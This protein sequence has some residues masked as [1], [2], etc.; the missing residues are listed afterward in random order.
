MISKLI[1]PEVQEFIQQ[2]V[3]EKP[4]DIA[5]KVQKYPHL[6][7]REIAGQ[8]A[9]R[10]KLKKKIP[11]WYTNFK[12]V[13]PPKENLEQASSQQTAEFKST[14][15]TGDTLLDLTG[16]TGVDSCFLSKKFKKGIYVEP[17]AMLCEL[18]RH[19]FDK[20]GASIDVV[21]AKAEEFL[22]TTTQH[23]DVIY[24]DPSRRTDTKERVF[25]LEQYSPNVLSFIGELRERGGRVIIKTSPMIDIKLAIDQLGGCQNVN[26]LA[27]ENEVKEVLF[28]LGENRNPAIEAINLLPNGAETRFRFTH[29]EERDAEV[30]FSGIENYI[31]D[32]NAAIRKAGGFKLS[33]F[34]FN[35]SKLGQHTHL[36]TSKE[37]VSNFPGRTFEVLEVLQP[38][39]KN[40]VKHV[41]S[42]KVNVMVRNYPET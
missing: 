5:L 40:V 4:T 7:I 21:H 17:D 18:A 26:V 31:Y 27:V 28:E 16:G 6:P 9:S 11:G 3:E 33:G 35:L 20:L 14:L 19:N 12:L 32:S 22:G 23:F 10:Q 29:Q 39:K 15:V 8:I 2:H 34:R 37:R 42:K 25:G 13:L 41:P 24:I 38:G 1:N 36:Y 30:T